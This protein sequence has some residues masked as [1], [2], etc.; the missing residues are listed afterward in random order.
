MLALI[1]DLEES[2]ITVEFNTNEIIAYM[3]QAT[4]K[5]ELLVGN[6][7]G[8]LYIQLPKKGYEAYKFYGSNRPRLCPR[9]SE[10]FQ[11]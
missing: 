10:R 9:M 5:H 3:S 11:C 8:N 4:K 6:L 7:V 1:E 2:E